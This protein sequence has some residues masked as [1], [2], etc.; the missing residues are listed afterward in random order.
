MKTNSKIFLMISVAILSATLILSS[1]HAV[2]AMNSL[3][4]NP[5]INRIG[6]QHYGL[7]T[8]N[9]VC[10][11]KLCNE[12]SV[13]H[14]TK[15]TPNKFKNILK[16]L[17]YNPSIKTERIFHYSKQDHNA[18]NAIFKITAGIKDLRNVQLFVRSDLE[19]KNIPIDGLF[20]KNN[21]AVQV[22]IH[23]Q[24]PTSINADI[25]SWDYSN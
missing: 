22:R 16:D 3:G 19:Q 12:P 10:G 17:A 13:K 23:A 18:Y 7:A 25:K 6:P 4:E 21:Q 24:D 9:I 5:S 2:Y 8:K 20:A 11:D 15:I 14:V 1:S